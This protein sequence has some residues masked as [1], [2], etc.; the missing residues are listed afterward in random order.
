MWHT[1]DFGDGHADM[2]R[3]L[4]QK[5]IKAKCGKRVS[6]D[7]V[8]TAQHVDCPDCLAACEHERAAMAAIGILDEE[9]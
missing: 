3:L 9:A 8:T 7:K 1:A 5:T 6:L 4:N 2:A